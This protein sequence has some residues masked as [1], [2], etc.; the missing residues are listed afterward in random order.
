MS[1]M[2]HVSMVPVV[3]IVVIEVPMMSDS[4][5]NG[6]YRVAA[7]HCSEIKRFCV[8]TAGTQ[9]FIELAQAIA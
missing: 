1:Y 2:V 5:S 7:V 4:N 6:R 8:S 3:V 9:A